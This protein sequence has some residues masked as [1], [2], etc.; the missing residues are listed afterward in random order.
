MTDITLKTLDGFATPT[1]CDRPVAEIVRICHDQTLDAG[2][3]TLADPRLTRETLEPLLIY[4]AERRCI[5]DNATC[6]GCHL[7]SKVRG[8]TS[9][10]DVVDAHTTIDTDEGLTLRGRGLGHLHVPSLDHLAK[11]WAGTELW[12]EARRVLR[13]L[14]HGVRSREAA[15]TRAHALKPAVILVEPQLPDNIGMVARAMANFGLEELRLVSPRDGWPNERA[16]IAASGATF[17]VDEA[18]PFATFEAALGNLNWVCATTA[19]QRDLAKPV[20][21]PEQAVVEMRRR[22]AAGERVGMVFGRERNGLETSEIANADAVVMIP[23][24]SRFASLNIAQAV[25]LLS[26]EWMKPD[27]TATLGRVTTYEQPREAGL[28]GRGFLPADKAQMISFFEHLESELDHSGF[29]NPPEKRPTL[30]QNLRSMFT[31]LGASEQ[32]VRTLRGIVKALVHGKG[33][34]RKV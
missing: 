21:T 28:H 23:V 16:R 20:L 29:F 24:D 10:D 2:L 7:R 22:I 30:V 26:Y 11:T 3:T 6:N 31:R 33:R 13:K 5:A 8:W 9:L 19:R 18:Q 1:A 27:P 34:G 12:F 32:E 14:R 15:P 4:C 25:L 17:I